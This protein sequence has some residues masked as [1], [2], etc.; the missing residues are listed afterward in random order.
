MLS[1]YFINFTFRNI[2]AKDSYPPKLYSIF[3]LT[4]YE[5]RENFYCHESFRR[6]EGEEIRWTS[7]ELDKSLFLSRMILCCFVLRKI[8]GLMLTRKMTFCYLEIFMYM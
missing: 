4:T 8:S 3:N 7:S 2:L 6:N 1:E 5:G